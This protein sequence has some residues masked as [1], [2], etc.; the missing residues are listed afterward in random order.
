VLFSDAEYADAV[1]AWL[2]HQRWFAAK[3]H[4]LTQVAVVA[5]APVPGVPTAEHVLVGVEVDGKHWQIYQVPVVLESQADD[6]TVIGAVG[7]G[8]L[9]DG[10]TRGDVVRG[11]LRDSSE[12]ARLNPAGCRET[13]QTQWL[14]PPAHLGE[15]RTLTVEQSNTSGVLDDRTMVKFFRMLSAGVNPDIEV[16]AG[17]AE[18]GS[19]DVGQLLG[20]VNGGW[21][22]PASGQVVYGHL[23]MIGEF[24]PASIDGWDLARQ[25]VARGADFTGESAALGA[26]TA[27]VHGDLARA[28]GTNVLDEPQVLAMAQRLHVRLTAASEI[29]TGLGALAPQLHERIDAITAAAEIP[30]QRVHGDYHLGQ[31]LRTQGGWR[32]LDFEGEP[33]GDLHTRRVLD[34]PMRD[35]AGMVRS[36]AY[37]AW[38]GGGNSG[39]ALEW[40]DR[41]R[42][43]FL[44]GYTAAGGP[45]PE[46]HRA[47][48]TAYTIDKT[49]YEA[50]YE[51][52]NRPDWLEIPLSALRELT[53]N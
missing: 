46:A 15:Y 28:F 23:A 27:R 39:S 19:H 40:R 49:A 35:V 4:R 17:L 48:L 2:P 29:V 42:Q 10:L 33:G 44:A 26:A 13:P 52:R 6:A 45:D 31:T 51:Q 43:A 47:L 41:C 3:G 30:V 21:R 11:L 50:V 14:H 8:I 18:V 20:W 24:F 7:D 9:H 32:V 1:A 36:F 34:H 37:A 16:H 12:K 25:E 38:Q 5:R 22:D 53:A